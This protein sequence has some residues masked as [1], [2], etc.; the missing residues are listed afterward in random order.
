MAEG[1]NR[2][3]GVDGKRLASLEASVSALAITLTANGIDVGDGDPLELAIGRIKRCAELE[4]LADQTTPGEIA[5]IARAEAAE[6]ALEAA[7]KRVAELEEENGEL[8]VDVEDLASAKNALANELAGEERP[9]PPP[10]PDAALEQ[11]KEQ[12]APAIAA[13][14]EL[15]RDVGPTFGGLTHTELRAAI[16]AGAAFDVVFSNGEYELVDF[17]PSRIKGT[18]LTR[19]DSS[20]FIVTPAIHLKGADH[21]HQLHGA[22]LL[23]EDVQVAYCPFDPPLTVHPGS[24]WRFERQILFG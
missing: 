15:A 18:D 13:R 5:A 4:A 20:R 6:T 19:V 10:S 11:A 1:R 12:P 2:G 8:K 7:R 21:P 14:P 16:D 23:L 17:E 22:G 24:D 3:A 9:L